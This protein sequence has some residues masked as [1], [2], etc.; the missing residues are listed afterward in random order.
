[1]PSHP[2][3]VRR[4][5]HSI[6]MGNKHNISTDEEIIYVKISRHVLASSMHASEIFQEV[7]RAIKKGIFDRWN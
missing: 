4:N 6:V 5:Y 7:I 3:R 2:D 1:M